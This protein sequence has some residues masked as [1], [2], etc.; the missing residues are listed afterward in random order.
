MCSHRKFESIFLICSMSIWSMMIITVTKENNIS[1]WFLSAWTSWYQ[2]GHIAFF[3]LN[4][5]FY[6]RYFRI[7]TFLTILSKT[8]V[9]NN[10][11]Q[12]PSIIAVNMCD[13][14]SQILCGI[15]ILTKQTTHLIYTKTYIRTMSWFPSAISNTA[16]NY[17]MFFFK[18]HF[19]FHICLIYEKSATLSPV[20]YFSS[21]T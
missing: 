20:Y 13:F 17:D 16:L 7:W 5:R 14:S 21:E 2:L 19:Y 12:I 8:I 11:K 10:S 6:F 9:T 4:V 3:Y 18:K 1:I 15:T